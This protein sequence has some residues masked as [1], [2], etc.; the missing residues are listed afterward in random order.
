MDGTLRPP[1]RLEPEARRE[2]IVAAAVC[3]FAEVGLG[4]TTRD[5]AQR[6]GVTQAL[7]YRYFSSKA[8]LLEAVFERVFLGRLD[9]RWIAE[10]RDRRVPLRDRLCRFYRQYAAAIFTYEWMRIFMW[11]GLAGEALNRRYLGHVAERLLAPLRE[12]IAADGSCQAPDMEA[13]W[14]LHGGI[15]YLG[16]RRFIYQLPAPDDVGPAIDGSVNRFLAGLAVS[17][18]AEASSRGARPSAGR[19]GRVPSRR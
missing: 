7:L 9:P 8:D 3:Y 5:L 10:I 11:A 6:A 1:R 17:P 18:S 12:E 16:I 13:M 15:V 19:S 14:A 4:G 2:Q